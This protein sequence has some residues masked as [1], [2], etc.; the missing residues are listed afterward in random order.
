MVKIINQ[1]RRMYIDDGRFDL[2]FTD[3]EERLRQS[4]ARLIAATGALLIASAKLNDTALGVG[5]PSLKK[6]L[7]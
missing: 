7:H 4:N 5:I 6:G 1:L 3:L 2:D